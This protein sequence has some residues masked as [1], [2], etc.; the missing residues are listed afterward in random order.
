MTAPHLLN[1]HYG[2]W[3]PQRPDQRDHEFVPTIAR[4][5][6]PTAFALD[7]TNIPVLDQ[8]QQ[9]S[10]TGHG[11]AGVVM[12][13]QKKQGE[14]IIVPSRAMLYYDA[15]LPEGTTGQDAGAQ[16]RDAVA[17][18]A[19]YGACPDSE[20]PYSDDVFNVAPSQQ[21]YADGT[22]QEAVVYE[23]IRYPHLNQALASGYPFVFGFTV[24]ESFE[25]DQSL[26]T[27]VVPIPANDEQ[28]LG[29]HCVWC[30][31]YNARFSSAFTAPNGKR[32]PPRSKAIRNSWNAT[33]GDGGDFYL[34]QWYFD[35]GQCS[36][37]WTVRRVGAK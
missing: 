28:V 8:G 20:F 34:P 10:C 16:V 2:G 9:G 13:D 32:I 18:L 26:S 29:G 19:Q 4:Q 1:Q 23:A 17:G 31:G 35:T 12:F 14:P 24:Y 5:A 36:D 33:V 22:R 25:G 30:W 3:H 6:A 21:D 7:I 27:G 15:R 37:F 11:T